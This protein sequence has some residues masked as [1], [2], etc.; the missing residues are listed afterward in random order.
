MGA[1]CLPALPNNSGGGN[2]KSGT[3][4][5][6]NEEHYWVSSMPLTSYSPPFGI[7][8]DGKFDIVPRADEGGTKST[9]TSSPEGASPE[10][11][12]LMMH[13]S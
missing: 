4:N 7:H 8:D 12:R 2:Q 11:L 1:V 10:L 3:Q 6:R 5:E 9:S 13:R